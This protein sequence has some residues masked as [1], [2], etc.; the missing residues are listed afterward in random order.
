MNF[1]QFNKIIQFY[2]RIVSTYPHFLFEGFFVF[3][4]VLFGRTTTLSPYR[5]PPF[6]DSLLSYSELRVVPH[7]Q[8]CNK[9]R[10][11]CIHTH[12]HTPNKYLKINTFFF[13][14]RFLHLLEFSF[15]ET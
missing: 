12:T 6:F 2:M 1:N 4:Y 15:E 9:F 7:L 13:I 8:N 5:F 14:Y 10:R 11:L 3:I